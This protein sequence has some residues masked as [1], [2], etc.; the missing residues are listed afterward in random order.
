[1]EKNYILTLNN[2]KKY[3][4]VNSLKY[5]GKDYVYLSL[6]SDYKDYMICEVIDDEVLEVKD[7]NLLG[8]LILEFSKVN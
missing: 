7:K 4:L 6:L 5:D 2:D 1:M 8:R 3:A